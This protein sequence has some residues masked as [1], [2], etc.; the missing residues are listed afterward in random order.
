MPE[1]FTISGI[2][3]S[4]NVDAVDDEIEKGLEWWKKVPDASKPLCP[5]VTVRRL[6][7]D[8][9]GTILAHL[10]V[11]KECP[12]KS[13]VYINSFLVEFV[14]KVLESYRKKKADGKMKGYN[15]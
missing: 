4:V 5:F 14:D 11:Y 7:P 3:L 6:C 1:T 15:I 2:T 12:F 13:G 8:I 10:D 9:C